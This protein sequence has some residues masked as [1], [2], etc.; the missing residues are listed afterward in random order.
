MGREI[1]SV[2]PDWE[3]PKDEKGRY[4]PLYDQTWLQALLSRLR[5]DFPWH[6][7]PKNWRYINEIAELWPNPKYYRPYWP[8]RR[9]T[10]FQ[11]YETVTEGT[12][13]SPVFA[14]LDELKNWLVEQ[15]YSEYAADKFCQDKWVP[16]AFR[17]EPLTVFWGIVVASEVPLLVA[18]MFSTG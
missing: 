5:Y 14:T 10:A 7:K 2:P 15:G 8:K 16:S 18:M 6:L 13:V 17:P 1:R 12:P 4:V 3:H 9:A 11:I